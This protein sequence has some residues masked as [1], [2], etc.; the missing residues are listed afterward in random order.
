MDLYIILNI[1]PDDDEEPVLPAFVTA[2]EDEAQFYLIELYRQWLIGKEPED[3][4]GEEDIVEFFGDAGVWEGVW[5]ELS[6]DE[7]E[8]ILDRA[9]C[10]LPDFRI[11][12]YHGFQPPES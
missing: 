5:S 6:I 11:V 8:G 3:V 2:S 4:L 10:T 7:I 12:T 1:N 9:Y